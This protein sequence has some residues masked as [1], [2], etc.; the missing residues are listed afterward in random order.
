MVVQPYYEPMSLD[1]VFAYFQD[2]SNAISIPIMVYNIPS[3]T[4]V[5]LSPAFLARLG[6]EI[7][8]VEYVKDSSGD[9]SQLQDLLYNYAA[10]VTTFNGWDTLTYSGLELGSKGSV[11]GAVNVVPEQC[12]A[13]FDLIQQGQHQQARDLWD[14][15]WPIMY[16]LTTEGYNASVKAGANLAGFRVGNPRRPQLPLSAEKTERLRQ[17]MVGA[18]ARLE[19]VAA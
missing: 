10:D 6:R 18:G 14:R 9:L 11:W 1:E 16:F 3:C 5:N 13:L 17:L 8:H 12:V 2:I 19:L 7:E 15:L 4:G